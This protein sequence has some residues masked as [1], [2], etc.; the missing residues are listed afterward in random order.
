M[1][2][3]PTQ[4]STTTKARHSCACGGVSTARVRLRSV[5]RELATAYRAGATVVRIDRLHHLLAG[6]A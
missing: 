2:E 4:G 3:T 5:E 1:D 6:G